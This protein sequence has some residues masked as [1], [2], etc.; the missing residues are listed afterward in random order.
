MGL[1]LI[2]TLQ[3]M[4]QG[5]GHPLRRLTIQTLPPTNHQQCGH[6][7]AVKSLS[8]NSGA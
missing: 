1:T 2:K 5:L 8:R 4:F 3:Q 7:A 6:E